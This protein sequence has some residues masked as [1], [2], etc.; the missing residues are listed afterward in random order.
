MQEDSNLITIQDF[1]LEQVRFLMPDLIYEA[2]VALSTEAD[3]RSFF[4]RDPERLSMTTAEFETRFRAHIEFAERVYEISDDVL[5]HNPKLAAWAKTKI[6]LKQE[7]PLLQVLLTYRHSSARSYA[8]DSLPTAAVLA[9]ELEQAFRLYLLSA[10][11]SETEGLTV[12]ELDLLLAEH[13]FSD[14]AHVVD[15]IMRSECDASV[16]VSLIELYQ[17]LDLRLSELASCLLTVAEVVRQ[18]MHV[19]TEEIAKLAAYL[20]DLASWNELRTLLAQY[21][22]IEF[23]HKDVLYVD[24]LLIEPNYMALNPGRGQEILLSVGIYFIELVTRSEE[25]QERFNR[26]IEQ[27]KLLAD[28]SRLKIVMLLGERP[29]YLKELADHLELSSATVSH[30]LQNMI[31]MELVQA[32]VTKKNRRVYYKLKSATFLELAD[33]IQRLGTGQGTW[34]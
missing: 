23:D 24:P 9:G 34:E 2:A 30:H 26:I 27:T 4:I 1:P 3:K 5:A 7:M 21:I 12:D 20:E 29:M 15:L 32:N 6:V 22:Q 25:D 18:E 13:D 14:L 16:K 28:A 31:N 10:S 8:D 33:T 19:F 17:A 11:G